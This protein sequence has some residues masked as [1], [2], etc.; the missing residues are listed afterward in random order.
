MKKVMLLF[1][2]ALAPLMFFGCGSSE[3]AVDGEF[4]AY[5]TGEHAEAPMVT[6]VT[7]TIEE[8]EIVSY[9][10]DARQGEW[11]EGTPVWNEQTKKELEED[12]GMDDYS[13][14]ER[15]W[16]LQA[17]DIEAYW[18]ENGV[19]SLELETDEDGYI[20]N[21]SGVTIKD[22]G[23][24]ELAQE[25]VEL[26]K[27]GKTNAVICGQGHSGP[28]LSSVELTL[29]E[30]GNVTD[31]VFD[32]L[33]SSYDETE[34]T[35]AWNDQTKQELGDDYGMKGVGNGYDFVD[36]AWVESDE[37]A[38]LEWYEQAELI[39]DYVLENG[40]DEDLQAV[41]GRGGSLDGET[42]VDGLAGV[43]IHSG[44]FYDLLHKAYDK[45]G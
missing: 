15:D 44:T 42:L 13:D 21:V 11:V 30:D 19:D 3:Y 35:F 22:G 18:L 29:D 24:S 14:A 10:I 12:Y 31:I 17:E 9:Y 7:V 16:Y 6:M 32:V 39:S 2:L 37:K 26:A 43:T 38:E 5:Q 27:A 28:D 36:G 25:A 34:E 23:Y 41:G 20:Q 33:Q 40:Y 45:I 4:T 8:G 1:V